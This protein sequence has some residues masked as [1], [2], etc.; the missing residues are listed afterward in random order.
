MFQKNSNNIY[1]QSIQKY[2]EAYFS[3]GA[4]LRG[5]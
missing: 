3:D 4:H 2:N 5:K 1:N